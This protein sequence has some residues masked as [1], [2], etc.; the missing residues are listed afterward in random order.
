M[1]LDGA[2]LW[3]PSSPKGRMND[4]EICEE[5]YEFIFGHTKFP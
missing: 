2:K 1:F 5:D 3:H 4:K